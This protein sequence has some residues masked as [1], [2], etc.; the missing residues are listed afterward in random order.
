[1]LLQKRPLQPTFN[2]AEKN[3]GFGCYRDSR[4]FNSRED[5]IVSSFR[6]NIRWKIQQNDIEIKSLAMED[7]CK[8]DIFR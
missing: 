7:K 5:F 2:T 8:S 4:P 6:Q 1:M 3:N